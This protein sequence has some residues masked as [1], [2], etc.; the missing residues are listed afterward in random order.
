MS[1]TLSNTTDAV[2]TNTSS[3]HGVLTAKKAKNQQ[4]LEG[5][6]ALNLI[7]SASIN[8]QTPVGNSGHNI[9]IKA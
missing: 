2:Q 7:Q 9:N 1:I 5:Q 6:M 4:E 8:T 3:A